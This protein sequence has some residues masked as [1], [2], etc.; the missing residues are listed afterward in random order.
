MQSPQLIDGGRAVLF[1]LRSGARP[2]DE[3]L[4]VV[5]DL[6]S[7]RRTTLV[8]AGT[9]AH[10]LPTGH[11]VYVR[12][13]TLFAMP[14]DE[15]TL[16]VKGGAVPMQQGIQA[17]A[18]SGAAQW[19]WSPH[20]TVAYIPGEG[21]STERALVWVSRDGRVEPATAPP[22]P[23]QVLQSGLRMS[24]DGGRVALTVD[25]DPG[26]SS[27][28]NAAVP[29]DSSDIWIWEVRR[30]T[31]TRLSQSGQATAPVWTPDGTRVCYRSA[32]EVLC[33]SP[34][35]SGPVQT[36]ATLPEVGTPKSFSSD[37]TRLL[38]HNVAANASDIFMTTIGSASETRPLFQTRFD[39]VGATISP[40]GKWLAYQSNETGRAEVYVRPFPDVDN[41]RWQIS[42]EGGVEPRWSRDGRELI[43]SFG[44]G[45]ITRIVWS[46]AIA[47]GRAFSADQPKI[48]AK[49]TSNFSVAY[50]V[51]P[52]GRL[53]FHIP[54]SISASGLTRLSQIVVAEHWFEELRVR[55]PTGN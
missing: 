22:R 27:A 29:P 39:E 1:T 26:S 5:Q 46:A 32:L 34:D 19:A 6:A 21:A 38:W 2:W 49:L 9:D 16:T 18:A 37:G 47:A 52:D 13:A 51:A 31:L 20:G 50:D 33:Q 7:G 23:I 42:S 14:F 28:T 40:D 17:T 44:G 24:P 54:A 45:P 48:M 35:G 25:A 8:E 55:V 12:D 15:R 30:N 41:G 4:I 3:A 36:L 11:L 53:L 43:F 10:L